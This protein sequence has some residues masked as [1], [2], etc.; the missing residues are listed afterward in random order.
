MFSILAIP[1]CKANNTGNVLLNVT[2]WGFRVTTVA[3]EMSE[4]EF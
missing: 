2:M 3:A 4:R 1:V